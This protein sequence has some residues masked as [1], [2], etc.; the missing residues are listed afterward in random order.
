MTSQ[1]ARNAPTTDPAPGGKKPTTSRTKGAASGA[2]KGAAAGPEGAA[3]GAVAGA[4]AA[5][6]AKKAARAAK[7]PGRGLAVLSNPR[8]AITAEAFV[9][10]LI[11][12]FSPMTDKHKTDPPGA[13]L[14]R[15][16]AV[17]FLFMILGI[18]STGGQRASKV[19]ASFGGLVTLALALSTRD[20]FLVLANRLGAADVPP[21]ETITAGPDQS[22]DN[23]DPGQGS[24]VPPSTPG[25][26][27]DPRRGPL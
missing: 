10:V 22:T 27:I 18:I 26:P 3:V 5:G 19:A 4:H 24:A 1:Q 23:P 12:A 15:M 11:V 2:A 8:K 17:V 14:K 9:C 20:I 21:Q 13:L 16:S 7:R 25:R 6:K